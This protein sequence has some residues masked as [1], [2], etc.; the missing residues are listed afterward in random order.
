M[1][2]RCEASWFP[3]FIFSKLRFQ[4]DDAGHVFIHVPLPLA[5]VKNGGETDGS[6]CKTSYC[7]KRSIYALY[8]PK[9]IWIDLVFSFQN[10]DLN[11]TQSDSTRLVFHGILS[12]AWHLHA[13]GTLPWKFS[14][15]KQRWNSHQETL[16]ESWGRGNRRL[17][18]KKYKPVAGW[19]IWNM[20][21]GW[22]HSYH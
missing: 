10:V 22:K 14:C 12:D 1:V 15:W 9:K 2:F 18:M 13:P 20:T 16:L 17:W 8:A 4:A 5:P 21:W 7:P 11:T 3:G 6:W 19:N